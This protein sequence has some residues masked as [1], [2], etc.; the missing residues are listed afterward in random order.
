MLW[1]SIVYIFSAIHPSSTAD[2]VTNQPSAVISKPTEPLSPTRSTRTLYDVRWSISELQNTS[3]PLVDAEAARIR[4]LCPPWMYQ[5]TTDSSAADSVDTN[6][7]DA[8]FISER[9]NYTMEKQF[10]CQYCHQLG[11]YEVICRGRTH[12]RQPNVA[13]S[14]YETLCEPMPYTLCM[15]RRVFRRM[16]PCNWSSGKR[17]WTA[18]LLSLFLGGFGVDRF[19]LGMWM[20]GLGKLFSFGGLGIWT[21]V[22]FL[23]ILAGYVKPPGDAVY[24]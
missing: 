9:T 20:E 4:L 10:V 21:V 12:C 5:P 6:T 19:Y 2:S 3:N 14:F 16:L 8:N 22:D 7:S 18:V 15:G 17:Y 24:V 1:I 13:R 11:D 23:L